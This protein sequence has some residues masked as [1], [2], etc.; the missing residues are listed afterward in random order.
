M[1]FSHIELIEITNWTQNV[2]GCFGG[3]QSKERKSEAIAISFRIRFHSV[4]LVE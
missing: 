2:L 3:S 4:F 1:T